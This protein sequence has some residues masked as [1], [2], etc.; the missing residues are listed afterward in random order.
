MKKE[1]ALVV[2]YNHRY[3]KNIDVIENIY[4]DR[5]FNIYH[6]MPFYQ[7]NKPNVIPVYE[8]SYYF[9]GYVAQGFN[10]YF[11]SVYEHYFFIADDLILNPAIN[12][13]NYK[14]VFQLDDS[15]GFVQE[16][17][18]MPAPAWGP[19]NRLAVNYDPF[20]GGTEISGEI[21]SAAEAKA[22][23]EQLNVVNSS[24]SL[25]QTYFY[26]KRY[27]FKFLARQLLSYLYDRFVLQTNLKQSRYPFV[28]SY[29]DIFIVSGKNVKKFIHLCGVFAATDMWVELAI[30]TALALSG[31]TIKVQRELKMQGKALWSASEL[32]ILDEFQFDLKNL[33]N[34]FPRDF[35]FLH[36]IK[37]SQWKK[38]V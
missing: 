29:S 2:I 35:I 19:Y 20:K 22:I 25:R 13:N 26:H 15:S 17:D 18:P 36:P 5:F 33:L 3:E 38:E 12:Q 23:L 11:K 34:N 10:A 24:Y 16:L 21:P 37:L 28:R 27:Q 1:V 30:P 4:K 32:E 6:L 7:G 14:E 9:Q 31:E 8:S